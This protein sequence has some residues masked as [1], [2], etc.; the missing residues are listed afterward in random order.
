MLRH[1]DEIPTAFLLQIAASH[2][3]VENNTH[4][5]LPSIQSCSSKFVSMMFMYKLI[6]G[7]LSADFISIQVRSSE[8]KPLNNVVL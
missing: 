1:F 7:N 6:R 3:S 4:P 8:K 5:S 2:T